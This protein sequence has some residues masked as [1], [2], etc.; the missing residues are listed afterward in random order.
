MDVVLI[1]AVTQDGF[2]ARHE[3]E[4]VTWSKDLHIFQEQTAGFPVIMGSNTFKCMEKPLTGRNVIVAHRNDKP[5]DILKDLNISVDLKTF[6]KRMDEQKKKARLAWKGSGDT[7]TDKFCLLY[8][9]PSPRDR[10]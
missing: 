10:G 8:T 9:S 1:A 4:T 5:K 3:H 2:I 7:R 6:E